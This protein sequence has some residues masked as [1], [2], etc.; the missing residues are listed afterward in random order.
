MKSQSPKKCRSKPWIK[1]R[2]LTSS[3]S[4]EGIIERRI[5]NK[6]AEMSDNNGKSEIK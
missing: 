6:S 1:T 3:D 4:I 5:G 2:I